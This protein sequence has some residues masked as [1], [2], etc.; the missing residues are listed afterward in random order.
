M[1]CRFCF[2]RTMFTAANS[3]VIKAAAVWIKEMRITITRSWK[4]KNSYFYD[5]IV[6]KY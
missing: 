4:M 1:Y 2:K 5:K 3:V 6:E